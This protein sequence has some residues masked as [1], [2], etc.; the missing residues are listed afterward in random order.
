MRKVRTQK[1]RQ[2]TLMTLSQ[3]MNVTKPP[4]V[5]AKTWCILAEGEFV[6]GKME[7]VRREIA[8][9]TK[10]MTF[11]A[12]LSLCD[13]LD[14]D[15]HKTMIT[16]PKEVRKIKGTSAKL[17]PGEVLSIHDLFYGLMLPSGND[18]A[19]TLARFFGRRVYMHGCELDNSSKN[20]HPAS[21]YQ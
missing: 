20:I 9:L 2:R 11:Y 14:I 4:E 8:S 10:M 6:A 17:K 1:Q 7:R 12:S 3:M 18:A 21:I 19:Y 15:Y 16:V 5:T 13:S